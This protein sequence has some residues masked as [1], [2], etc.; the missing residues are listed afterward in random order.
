MSAKPTTRA[1]APGSA[2]NP[3]ARL[4]DT[5]RRYPGGGTLAVTAGVIA[6]GEAALPAILALVQAFDGF[7][8]DNDPHGEHDFGAFEWCG[9]RLFW[10]IDCYDRRM[11]FGSPDPL[12]PSVTTRVLTIM[13]ASEW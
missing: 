13:L 12:D 9:E 8:P 10:K 4:N 11:Q 6:L 1:Q 2:T 5:F 3:L 7:N